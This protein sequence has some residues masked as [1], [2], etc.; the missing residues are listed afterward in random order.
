MLPHG[1]TNGIAG[2]ASSNFPLRSGK[3]S[4]FQGGVRA[5]SFVT[6]GFVPAAARGKAVNGLLQHVD[7][8]ATFAALAGATIPSTEGLNVWDVVA[9]GAESPRTEVPLNVDTSRVAKA[10]GLAAGFADCDC[11]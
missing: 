9:T 6:G 11:G 2:S 3:A 7:I 5:V 4:L 8:P 10:A 1:I